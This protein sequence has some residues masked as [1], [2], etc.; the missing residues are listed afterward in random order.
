MGRCE[1]IWENAYQFNPKRHLKYENSNNNDSNQ[2]PSGVMYPDPCKFP[3]FNLMP[4]YCLGK[5]T[6]ILEAK[7]L[8]TPTHICLWQFVTQQ[9]KQKIKKQIKNK[10][11]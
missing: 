7:V 5:P 3:A 6:A 11:R 8:K 1:W 10:K 4:R 9:L 2:Q